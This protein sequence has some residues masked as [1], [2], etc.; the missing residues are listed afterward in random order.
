[1]GNKKLKGEATPEQIAEWKKKYGEVF[2][3]ISDGMIGYLRKP[4]RPE[5][6]YAMS[7][8]NVN[9]LM[10]TETIIQSCWLGGCDNLRDDDK[11]FL[12]LNTQIND[13]IEIA[14][15]EVKKF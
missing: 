9:P 3:L 6:G 12:G 2:A 10:M 11:Y 4:T 7:H 8:A 15:V 5:L 1:M 14:E 13:I